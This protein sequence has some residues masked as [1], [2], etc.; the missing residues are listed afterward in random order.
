MIFKLYFYHVFHQNW[1]EWPFNAS[2][3]ISL[4]RQCILLPIIVFSKFWFLGHLIPQPVYQSLQTVS[5]LVFNLLQTIWIF[6]EI[7]LIVIWFISLLIILS[8]QCLV[9]PVIFLSHFGFLGKSVLLSSD[10]SA[11]LSVFPDCVL[12]CL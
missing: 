4:P 7:C 8:R 12:S 6:G 3:I 9:L 2:I 1:F 5:C 10:S 11:S